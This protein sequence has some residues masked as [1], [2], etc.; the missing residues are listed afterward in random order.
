MRTHAEVGFEMLTPSRRP[1]LQLA[2]QIAMD[3]HENWDGS[4]YPRGLSGEQ[5]S[6]G[7]RITMLAD[8]YDA[9][10]SRRC[11][12]EPWPTDRI[13]AFMTEQRGRKFD[14]LLIDRLLA[15]WD[16]ALAIRASLPDR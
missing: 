11:Y 5:I 3:H 16:E 6:I 7:G 12:K 2:A 1:L 13:R 15:N 9:L 8:V 14:P 10:G 4:G